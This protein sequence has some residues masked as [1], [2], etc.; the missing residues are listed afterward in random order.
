MHHSFIRAVLEL[1][2]IDL[3][4]SSIG[5]IADSS[6]GA[7]KGSRGERGGAKARKQKELRRKVEAREVIPRNFPERP[8]LGLQ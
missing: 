7:V 3:F 5:K 1:S 4:L 2:F 8:N 6:K